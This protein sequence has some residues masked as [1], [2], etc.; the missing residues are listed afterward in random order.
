MNR[1]PQDLAKSEFDCDNTLF[2]WSSMPSFV[3][4]NKFFSQECE[5]KENSFND[6]N[7]PIF[8]LKNKNPKSK[9][10]NIVSV[11]KHTN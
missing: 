9:K 1:F 7:K 8:D 6:M 10:V 4:S 11:H 2:S 5:N 3:S